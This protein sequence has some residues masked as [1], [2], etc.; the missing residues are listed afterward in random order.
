[1]KLKHNRCNMK[2]HH[3]TDSLLRSPCSAG[4]C[5]R[6]C[7]PR[8]GAPSNVYSALLRLY[9]S[10]QSVGQRLLQLMRSDAGGRNRYSPTTMNNMS[11]TVQK[12]PQL[13][14]TQRT[15]KRRQ[16]HTVC[17]ARAGRTVEW[18]NTVPFI[19][20]ERMC[21]AHTECTRMQCIALQ[22][23]QYRLCSG[24]N[25]LRTEYTFGSFA[26]VAGCCGCGEAF[27]IVNVTYK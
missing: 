26:F 17:R 21:A 3:T 13:D 19:E 16:K 8:N 9:A 11:R 15:P 5:R 24:E 4:Y 22:A 6:Q 7:A 23:A 12:R 25:M 2:G 10:K 20:C 27:N 1:M 18:W 14:A